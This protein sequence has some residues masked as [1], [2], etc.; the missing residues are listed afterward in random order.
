MKSGADAS[1]WLDLAAACSKVS[2][3]YTREFF[4][5]VFHSSKLGLHVI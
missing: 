5:P 4:F 1:F 3:Y 2:A